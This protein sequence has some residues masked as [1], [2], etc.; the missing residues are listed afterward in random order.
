MAKQEYTHMQQFMPSGEREWTSIRWRFGG[1]DRRDT[2]DTGE[3]SDMVGISSEQDAMITDPPFDAVG[4]IGKRYANP[5][6]VEK[7][8]TFLMVLYLSDGGA[9]MA[10]M[11]VEGYT[12]TTV[13][14]NADNSLGAAK[15]SVVLF[16]VCEMEDGNILTATFHPTI[17]IFPDK[18]SF[19]A[20]PTAGY[21]MT[22]SYL[23]D[24]F[25]NLSVATSFQGRLFG[26]DGSLAYASGYNDYANWD[27][28]T[29]DDSSPAHAWV[30]ATQT[31][32]RADDTILAVTV[33][34]GHVILFKRGYMHAIYGTENPFRLY[35]IGEY[36]CVGQRALA[37]CGGILYF[38]SPGGIMAYNGDSVVCISRNVIL[39]D[40]RLPDDTV[41]SADFRYLYVNAEGLSLRYDTVW[42]VWTRQ[43]L[44][45]GF[46]WHD[47]VGN[48][49]HPNEEF[50]LGDDGVLYAPNREISRPWSAE[51]DLMA[52][53]SLDIRRVKKI[54][55]AGVCRTE[56]IPEGEEA[57]IRVYL[58][59]PGETLS[60]DSQ[61]IAE[62]VFGR[63]EGARFMLRSLVRMTS[64]TAHRLV[65]VGDGHFSIHAIA[66]KATWPGRSNP[67]GEGERYDTV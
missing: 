51:T 36:G 13:T 32:V 54:T 20:T 44:P 18:Y 38:A 55:V 27:L 65:I 23:G 15:R 12:P 64:D 19:P 21:G 22:A 37:Q 67:P 40:E 52:M 17:L 33:Y 63:N 48:R 29:A 31:N 16:N 4:W 39:G 10:D 30:T 2:I 9:L 8:D 1:I 34:G 42:N 24:E 45:D 59:H 47:S 58:L 43:S 14:I 5:I 6:Q 56:N 7:F 62:K 25:P 35:D 61:L 26:S 66:M 57:Y 11:L 50:H 60:P 28:D 41:L 3:F 46:S 53:G 49:A